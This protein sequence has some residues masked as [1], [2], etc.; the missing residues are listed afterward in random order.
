MPTQLLIA[1]IDSVLAGAEVSASAVLPSSSIRSLGMTRQGTGLVV[2]EGEY[3]GHESADYDVEIV[4]G[5]GT[6]RASTPT[7][8]GV[9]S[10]SLNV[11]AADIPAQEVAVTLVRPPFAGTPAECLVGSDALRAVPAGAAGNR[12]RID[13]DV[14]G[15]SL[16]P[17]G[18]AT[19]EEV[20]A[21]QDELT[22]YL[23]DIEGVVT[24]TDLSGN[25]SADAPRVRFGSDPQ[26]YRVVRDYRGGQIRTLLTPAAVRVI[27]KGTPIIIVTG[28]YSVTVTGEGLGAGGADIV[29]SYGPVAQI[30]TGHDLLLAL[31]ASGLLRPA[32][33]PAPVTTPGG[34]ART[35]LP[36][37]TGAYAL[38]EEASVAGVRP[39][40]LSAR[41]AALAD[42]ITLQCRGNGSWSVSGAALG[43]LPD[44]REGERYA[45]AA[46]P[47]LLTIPVRPA[48]GGAGAVR[49]VELSEVSLVS[50]TEGELIPNI[51]IEGRLGINASPRTIT[52][53]YTKRPNPNDCPCS[54][55]DAPRWSSSCLGL[56]LNNDEGGDIL[57]ADYQSRLKDL[58]EWQRDFIAGNTE[59]RPIQTF[60]F[61]GSSWLTADQALNIWTPRIASAAEGTDLFG[62]NWLGT[63]SPINTEVGMVAEDLKRAFPAAVTGNYAG[64]FVSGKAATDA[65]DIH[66]CKIITTILAD[67]LAQ[68]YTSV[69][70]RTAWDAMFLAVQA[71]LEALASDSGI[72]GTDA[73]TDFTEKY[74]AAADYVLT[75]AGIVPGKTSPVSGVVTGCWQ[76]IDG[77]EFWWV[78]SDGYAPAFSGVEYYSTRL[79]S[80]EN[81]KE[82]AFQIR[83]G[84]E[85]RLKEGDRLTI[86]IGGALASTV[87]SSSERLMI[88][89]IPSR[90]L[91]AVGG[92]D[93]D[94]TESWTV[95]ARDG[96]NNPLPAANLTAANRHYAA[97]GLVFDLPSGGIPF[98]IG[99][100]FSFSVEGGTFRWRKGGDAWSAAIPIADAT[101]L[102]L[103]L[104]VSFLAGQAPSFAPGDLYRFRALQDAA[105]DLVLTPDAYAWQWQ[106]GPADITMLWGTAR[107]ITAIAI[108]HALP[109]GA[110]VTAETTSNGI[111]WT[112]LPWLSAVPLRDWLHVASGAAVAVVGLRLTFS[113]AGAVRWIWAG[114]P[115]QP[116]V[117]AA[118][119]LRHVYDMTRARVAGASALMAEGTGAT[120]DWVMLSPDDAAKLTALVRGQKTI[121]DV[122]LILVPQELHLNEAYLCRVDGD[123][124]EVTDEFNYEPNDIA[125]RS[126]AASLELA[127]EWRSVG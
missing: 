5:D 45:P 2:L 87:W 95:A 77:E 60:N 83:C 31:I 88:T 12:I 82:F 38:I 18:A 20:A 58:Y 125:H 36:V 78:L 43:A 46:S 29:E 14:S 68:V 55:V 22:G 8:S 13:V 75:C 122:P 102:E 69:D 27:P 106:A 115:F 79:G 98:A 84:C 121:G 34:N 118:L 40:D 16:A 85:E 9:G 101:L 11:G 76:D 25:V 4:T 110:T 107:D 61:N 99:D 91:Y 24:S 109:A 33:T 96:A 37:A 42:T 127:P 44:A 3:V 57:D 119:R 53:T 6:G 1:H 32:Y 80:Y 59:L 21:E 100:K 94:D 120:M 104:S 92:L 72:L 52:A 41:P 93:A 97:G 71:E 117:N 7:F 116:D 17:S 19:L 28:Y 70:G 15:L 50:R 23:W 86:S 26:V 30:V 54:D 81:T 105:P 63:L 111:D 73:T 124:F 74:F 67:C 62:A 51:C 126:I 39:L 90:P 47:V 89:V 108:T 113:T 49:D 48:I 56:D 123:E 10:G 66:L 64:A 114:K 35:D 103:G 112:P 65:S